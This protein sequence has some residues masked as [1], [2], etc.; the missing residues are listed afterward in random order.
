MQSID[1]KT[2]INCS[3]PELIDVM[4]TCVVPRDVEAVIFQSL[5]LP[6]SKNEKTTVDLGKFVIYY[7]QKV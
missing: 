4:S 1:Q 7:S 5:P 6:L 3:N 2:G